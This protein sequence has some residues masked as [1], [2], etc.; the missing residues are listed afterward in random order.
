MKFYFSIHLLV[1][2]LLSWLPSAT[3]RIESDS[4]SFFLN[5]MGPCWQPTCQL[6]TIT[7]SELIG[8]NWPALRSTTRL[9]LTHVTSAKQ[10]LVWWISSLMKGRPSTTFTCW[11]SALALTQP[12][13]LEPASKSVHCRESPVHCRLFLF[14]LDSRVLFSFLFFAVRPPF[15]LHSNS[16]L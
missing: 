14:F 12:D 8:V 10:L 4:F 1:S 9:P 13:G 15:S 3:F 11:D 6:A 7:S 5:L 2:H 16:C